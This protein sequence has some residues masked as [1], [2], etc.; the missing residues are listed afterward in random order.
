MTNNA[1]FEKT[2][3]NVKKHKDIKLVTTEKKKISG[4]RPKLSH[5]KVLHRKF[6]S[7]RNEKK[8]DNFEQTCPLSTFNIRIK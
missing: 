2:V 6:I 5:Y 7:H 4:V 8:R 3:E 1:V